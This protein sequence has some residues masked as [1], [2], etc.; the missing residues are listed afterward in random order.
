MRR[1][2]AAQRPQSRQ[3]R[4]RGPPEPPKDSCL[5]LRRL[6][7]LHAALQLH[8]AALLLHSD[9]REPPAAARR[10]PNRR[11]YEQA[12]TKKTTATAPPMLAALAVEPAALCSD[13]SSAGQ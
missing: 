3:K 13:E 2:R 6:A 1:W 5:A 8:V 9:P 4:A 11:K 12:T 7:T 10:A